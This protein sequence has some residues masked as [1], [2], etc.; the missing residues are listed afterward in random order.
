MGL[1]W[2]AT[3]DIIILMFMIILSSEFIAYL[4]IAA[5]SPSSNSLLYVPR[6]IDKYCIS[7]I[8]ITKNENPPLVFETTNYSQSIF[9]K[10]NKNVIETSDIH[11]LIVSH[12]NWISTNETK[13]IFCNITEYLIKDIIIKQIIEG[14]KKSY[15]IFS[16]TKFEKTEKKFEDEIRENSYSKLWLNESVKSEFFKE[17]FENISTYENHENE[18]IHLE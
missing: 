9:C 5:F 11:K 1:L 14:I 10:V 8:S 4:I 17:D 3:L 12:K 13:Y 6:H 15:L 16:I 2:G 7:I 18:K